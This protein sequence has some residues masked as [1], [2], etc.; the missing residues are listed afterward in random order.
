MVHLFG[1]KGA[2]N[3]ASSA[4]RDYST[5]STIWQAVAG[6]KTVYIFSKLST[7]IKTYDESAGNMRASSLSTGQ[8]A[9][10]GFGGLA[11]GAVLGTAGTVLVRKRKKKEV[12]A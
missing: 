3:I 9:I 11:L 1:E 6:D 10:F 2:V 4:F 8:A 7:D 5:F 12:A